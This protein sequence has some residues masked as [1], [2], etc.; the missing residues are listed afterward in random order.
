MTVNIPPL[1]QRPDDIELLTSYFIKN[2][3][4]RYSKKV[5]SVADSVID[6]FKEYTWPGNVRELLHVLEYAF[7]IMEGQCID[8]PCLP[9]YFKVQQSQKMAMSMPAACNPILQHRTLEE[10][11]AEYEQKV[12][13]QVLKDFNY[14][15]SKTAKVLGIKRQSLQYRLKKYNVKLTK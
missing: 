1:R 2:L 8:L 9:K 7:N 3:S 13:T 12:V 15:V 6:K 14:N 4:C 5:T 11:M 10:L